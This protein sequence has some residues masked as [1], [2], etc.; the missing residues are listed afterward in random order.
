MQSRSPA[1]HKLVLV[2]APYL[3]DF[4]DLRKVCGF[5]D[6]PGPA[7]K[8]LAAQK[9]VKLTVHPE[10]EQVIHLEDFAR[11]SLSTLAKIYTVSSLLTP[12]SCMRHT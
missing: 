3:Q 10:K 2:K 1:I 9:A 5:K 6:L 12:V 7:A 8:L 4:Q 11:I